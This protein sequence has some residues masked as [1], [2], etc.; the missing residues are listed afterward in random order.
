[1]CRYSGTPV[2]WLAEPRQ[3]RSVEWLNAK[4]L[5]NTDTGI[6]FFVSAVALGNGPK[7]FL[8]SCNVCFSSYTADLLTKASVCNVW[9]TYGERIGLALVVVDVVPVKQVA[10]RRGSA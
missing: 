6:F 5:S 1:M 7:H 2:F 3:P 9:T 10:G 4:S 8:N